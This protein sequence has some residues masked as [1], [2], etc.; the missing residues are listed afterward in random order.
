MRLLLLVAPLICAL[1]A[2]AQEQPTLEK[3]RQCAEQGDAEAQFNLGV[4]YLDSEGPQ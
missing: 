4:V 3:L 1:T 2:S